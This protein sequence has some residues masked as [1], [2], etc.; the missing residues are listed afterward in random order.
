MIFK[1]V[2]LLCIAMFASCTSGVLPVVELKTNMGNILMEIDTLRA[3]VSGKN[4][5]SL[6]KDGAL[7]AAVFYRVVR[8]D[9]QPVNK[10][11]I[12]VIQGGLFADSLMA[13]YP[14]IAHEP[15]SVT[16][17][18]HFDGVVSMARSE[19]GSASTEFFICIGDQ[20][21]LDFGGNRNPDGQGFAAFGKVIKGMEVV[22]RIQQMRDTGQYLTD[23]VKINAVYIAAP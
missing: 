3:P 6:V 16:G 9:N 23:P 22:R 20:P 10:V 2:A 18:R 15:T 14:A 19:P 8:P 1:P 12:E 11:K 13:K 4:F 5:L 7:D 17:I 21:A